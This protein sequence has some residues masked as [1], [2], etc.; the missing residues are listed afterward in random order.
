VQYPNLQPGN[1][2][3][4]VS[5]MNNDG[6]W[7]NVPAHFHFVIAPPLWATWWA[8]VLYV[9]LLIGGVYAWIKSIE[10]RERRKTEINKQ[11]VA[12]EIRELKSQFDPHFLF[13]SLNTLV[14][15]VENKSDDAPEF[16]NEL[17]KFYRYSLQYRSQELMELNTEI[18]QA[19]RY[20]RLLKI[21]L[22]TNL[23]TVGIL[24]HGIMNTLY[25][26]MP[27]SCW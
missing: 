25:L 15:L 23:K 10:T 13:N 17:S 6:V 21:R 26:H 2:T 24:T 1:Y 7:N 12:A 4:L 22:A 5:A 20:I 19:K 11:R 14:H 9:A 18:T 3:F 27:C 8:K 16:I